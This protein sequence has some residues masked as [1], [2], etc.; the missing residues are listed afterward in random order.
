MLSIANEVDLL[1]FC[2]VCFVCDTNHVFSTHNALK[3]VLNVDLEFILVL[4]LHL[5]L[6]IF[7]LQLM[8]F[9]FLKK[10]TS[11]VFE[12]RFDDCHFDKTVFPTLSGEKSLPEAQREIIWNA[13]TL[14]HL[15]PRTKQCELEVWRIIYLQSI[16]NQLPDVFINNKKIVKSHIPAANTLAIIEVPVGQS[17]N[18]AT[19]ESKPC[20]KRG[21]L[22]RAKDKIPRKRK[23]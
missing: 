20:L 4:I 16:A 18:T 8:M 3:W 5:L 2:C 19:N 21:R 13:L 12:V 14:S 9:L 11:D 1:I 7:N 22:V 23:M 6:D 17:I 10:K 15:D